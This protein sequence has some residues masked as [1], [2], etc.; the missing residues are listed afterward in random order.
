MFSLVFTMVRI[1]SRGLV[2]LHAF[3]K[4]RRGVLCVYMKRGNYM[5]QID[6]QELQHLV[7]TLTRF[8]TSMGGGTQFGP[9]IST[10]DEEGFPDWTPDMYS[11]T[12][13]EEEEK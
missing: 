5:L 7:N 4:R 6:L 3:A 11:L 12:L 9:P 13:V 1:Y 10:G 2:P 8:Y